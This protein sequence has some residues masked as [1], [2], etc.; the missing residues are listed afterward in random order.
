MSR[1]GGA[2]TVSHQSRAENGR[3]T[4]TPLKE[5]GLVFSCAGVHPKPPS[6]K[7]MMPAAITALQASRESRWCHKRSP[8]RGCDC[9]V[10]GC[11]FPGRTSQSPDRPKLQLASLSD[12]RNMADAYAVCVVPK[13]ED[14][15]C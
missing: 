3:Q 2:H 5:V 6:R 11:C 4:F 15:H 7:A 9:R 12:P 13:N 1:W 14:D 10:V 8:R